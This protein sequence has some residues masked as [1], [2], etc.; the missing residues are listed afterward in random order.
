MSRSRLQLRTRVLADQ[1]V[2]RRAT[3]EREQSSG[4]SKPKQPP[5]SAKALAD[6]HR[7]Y[8]AHLDEVFVAFTGSNP[9]KFADVHEGR[10]FGVALRALGRSFTENSQLARQRNADGMA[11]LEKFKTH[12]GE[13]NMAR[14][15]G[16]RALP[17]SKLSVLGGTQQFTGPAL[18]AN[19]SML[20]YTDTVLIPDPVLPWLEINQ[21]EERFQ[22]TSMLEQV[23][24]LSRLRPL[25]DAELPYPAIAVFPSFEK[26]LEDRDADHSGWDRRSSRS[27]CFH[28][29]R[30]RGSRT[31]AR[32]WTLRRTSRAALPTSFRRIIFSFHPREMAANRFRMRFASTWNTRAHVAFTGLCKRGWKASPTQCSGRLRSSSASVRSSMW[33]RTRKC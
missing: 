21:S 19:A 14:V 20:L 26:S 12:L 24:Y 7:E 10:D 1:R 8:F 30:T 15:R 28:T 18:A 25:V 33:Q 16:S 22:L 9:A 3:R 27:G 32:S 13:T 23:F 11:A 5:V 6:G 29:T 4:T 17:G 31:R 2:R